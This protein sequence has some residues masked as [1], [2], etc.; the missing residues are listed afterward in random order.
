MKKTIFF[1]VL[2]S[3]LIL[4][5]F[6]ITWGTFTFNTSRS[7]I[8]KSISSTAYSDDSYQYK[9]TENVDQKLDQLLELG[10]YDGY[11]LEELCS[12]IGT[13]S[14]SINYHPISNNIDSKILDIA[15][16]SYNLKDS[17]ATYFYFIDGE[18]YKSKNDEFNGIDTKSLDSF[19]DYQL[20]N[21]K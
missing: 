14:Y 17:T 10:K 16:Y 15:I 4:P 20:E 11:S 5:I 6:L 1:L 7:S 12:E 19:L 21:F 2:F 13:P 9:F 3:I 8:T 18:F